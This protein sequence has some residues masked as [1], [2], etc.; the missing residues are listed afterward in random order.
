MKPL[1]IT[2]LLLREYERNGLLLGLLVVVPLIFITL[3]IYTTEDIPISFLV[4]DGGEQV[5]VSKPMPDVHGAI[6]VPITAAFLASL[7]GL[8][9]MVGA[10][11]ND[12]RLIVAGAS[13]VTV[14]SA[15]L[16]LIVVLTTVVTLVSVGVA[17]IDFRPA[18]LWSFVTANVLVGVTYALIGV[19]AALLVGRL[20]GAFLMFTLPMIDIG[21]YQDPM[22]VSGEQ[23]FWMKLLPGFG[24]TRLLLDAGFTPGFDEWTALAFAL[25]WLLA[26]TGVVIFVLSS[27]R[28]K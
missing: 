12:A 2:A 23:A 3:A 15:R 9:T 4:R 22:L 13:S 16:A 25:A 11:R 1:A 28:H 27:V 5:T 19:L 21:I 8:F 7:V 6:M 18:V 17:L 10:A 14:T 26:L 24:G 20:G